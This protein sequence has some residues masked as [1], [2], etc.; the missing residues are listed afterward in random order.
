MNAKKQKP[1]INL[2]VGQKVRVKLNGR[3]YFFWY[4]LLTPKLAEKL[5]SNLSCQRDVRDDLIEHYSD[6]QEAGDWVPMSGHNLILDEEG[7]L[8]DGMQRCK[9][10]IR[11]GKSY[12]ATFWQGLT[13]EDAKFVTNS[14]S[15]DSAAN[16]LKKCGVD[17]YLGEKACTL[18]YVASFQLTGKTSRLPTKKVTHDKNLWRIF[19][20]HHYLSLAVRRA[21]LIY[22]KGNLLIPPSVLCYLLYITYY[23]DSKKA[24]QFCRFMAGKVYNET[25]DSPLTILRD[26]LQHEKNKRRFVPRVERWNLLV[27]AWNLF[28][29]NSKITNIKDLQTPYGEL[30][31]EIQNAFGEVVTFKKWN[32]IRQKTE[33]KKKNPWKPLFDVSEKAYPTKR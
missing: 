33:S 12:I 2:S 18:N 31:P 10:M 16:R 17:E 20:Q 25:A 11:T 28:V 13:R 9:T 4:E 30:D 23:I 6:I 27:K 21:R 22:N 24:M 14:A 7:G 19:L 32:A 1:I 8:A 3:V 26:W 15:K 29:R 5:L